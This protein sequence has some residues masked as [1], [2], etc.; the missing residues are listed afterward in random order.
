VWP[1]WGTRCARP[2]PL[3]LALCA[4]GS[5][6]LKTDYCNNDLYIKDT[7]FNLYLQ[8]D[9]GCTAEAVLLHISLYL[10]VGSFMIGGGI[11]PWGLSM[12]LKLH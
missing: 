2:L 3:Q 12:E 11:A 5:Q 8:A 10:Y 7:L 9:R 4:H 1:G 6:D